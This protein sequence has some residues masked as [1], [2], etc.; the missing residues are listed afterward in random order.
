MRL[1][2]MLLPALLLAAAA[3]PPA[4]PAMTAEQAL[5]LCAKALDAALEGHDG[6]A[7]VADAVKAL[8]E[9]QQRAVLG[10][11]G[12]YMAGAVA[13]LKHVTTAPELP[14]GKAVSI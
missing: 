1:F 11:C 14:A 5:G 10:L 3:P 8:P 9:E 12:V 7:V 2:A 6:R 4:A 13:M